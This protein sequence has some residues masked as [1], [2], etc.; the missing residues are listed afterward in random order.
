MLTMRRADRTG[1]PSVSGLK[2]AALGVPSAA[3]D[4]RADEVVVA[5][6]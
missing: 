2:P 1:L 6:A 3:A 4:G 5:R